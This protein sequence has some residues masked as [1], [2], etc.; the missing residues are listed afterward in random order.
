MSNLN[1]AVGTPGGAKPG[2]QA[3]GLAAAPGEDVTPTG[4]PEPAPDVTEGDGGI[5]I[6]PG[7]QTPGKSWHSEDHEPGQSEGN[8]DKSLEDSFPASD[9]PAAVQPP[10][11]APDKSKF[12]Y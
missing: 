3:S 8:L 12:N 7:T 11:E 1:T 5:D 2:W 4:I 10:K 6:Q 9:V